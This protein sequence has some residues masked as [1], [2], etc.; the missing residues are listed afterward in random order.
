MY[1]KAKVLIGNAFINYLERTGNRTLSIEKINN[2][3]LALI[4]FFKSENIDAILVFSKEQIN[5]F[6]VV[7]SKWFSF[8]E[9]DNLIILHDE[10]TITQ[11]IKEFY[12]HMTSSLSIAFKDEECIKALL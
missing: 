4:N 2:Y 5:D 6:I 11:L 12:N 1:I 9:S 8:I 3:G 10:V 7:Y